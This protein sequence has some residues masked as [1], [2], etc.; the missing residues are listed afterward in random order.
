MKPGTAPRCRAA[1]WRSTL[2][3][4][5]PAAAG[6]A[7]LPRPPPALEGQPEGPQAPP[8]VGCAGASPPPFSSPCPNPLSLLSGFPGCCSAASFFCSWEVLPCCAPGDSKQSLESAHNFQ[9]QSKCQGLAQ[10][11][12]ASNTTIFKKGSQ[13]ADKH[14]R[15]HL[16]LEQKN[17]S[18]EIQFPQQKNP[19]STIASRATVTPNGLSVQSQLSMPPSF[20]Q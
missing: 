20:P 19:L 16:E 4:L 14:L 8:N 18:F 15:Q 11:K 7:R 9:E 3:P 5:R 10:Q 1:S 2:A 13:N 6:S 17:F 12:R